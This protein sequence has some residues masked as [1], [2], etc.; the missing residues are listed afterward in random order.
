[1]RYDQITPTQQAQVSRLYGDNDTVMA[2]LHRIL[3][4]VGLTGNV[5]SVTFD[6]CTGCNQSSP[7]GYLYIGEN[8]LCRACAHAR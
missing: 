1:M 3:V 7:E 5:Q 8:Q 4:Q 6:W 2:N